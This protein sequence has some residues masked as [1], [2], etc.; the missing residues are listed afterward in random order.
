MNTHL[1]ALKLFRPP[2]T[3]DKHS[4]DVV[5]KWLIQILAEHGVRE[6]DI[7]GAVTDGGTDI[8]S[9]VEA[10]WSWEW[11]I[12]HLLNRATVDATGMSPT[13]DRSKNPDCRDLLEVIKG[14]VEH[15]N[16]SAVDKVRRYELCALHLVFFF[17]FFLFL[18]VFFNS[19]S[20]L[21]SWFRFFS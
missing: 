18:F 14:M 21:F 2:P 13:R 9:G 20:D 16:R 17:A 5:F 10:A 19:V 15:F 6:E 3:F 4:G 7:G 11:C 12:P 8:R 1:L